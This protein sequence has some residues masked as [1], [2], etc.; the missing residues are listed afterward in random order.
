MTCKDDLLADV[1]SK[2]EGLCY[3][4][5]YLMFPLYLVCVTRVVTRDIDLVVVVTCL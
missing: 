2:V 5:Q 1:D 4:R 3:G